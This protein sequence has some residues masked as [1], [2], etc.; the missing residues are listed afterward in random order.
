MNDALY[1]ISRGIYP[2]SSYIA[3]C[4]QLA[5]CMEV[6]ASPKP[7]NIDRHD[8]YADTRYEHFLTSAS[9][10][11]PVV[12]EASSHEKG[13]GQFIKKAV[14]ESVNWQNGGNTHFGAFILL[15]PLAMAAGEIFQE[16]ETFTIQQLV[17]SAYRIVKNTDTEDSINFYSCF[18]AAGVK[19]NPVD[20]FDLRD[21]TAIDELNDKNMTL[22]KLMDIARGYDIIANEWVTGFKRCVRCAETIIDGMNGLHAPKIGADINDVT[23]YAFLKILSENEDTFISTKYNAQTALYVSG[24]AK[25]IIEEIY[26]INENFDTILPM[27]KKLDSELLEKKINPGSTADIVI[28]GLFI[29]LLAGV[30]F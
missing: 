13:V 14:I 21:S 1:T 20:E 17:E 25:K 12:E 8:N 5:M 16:D 9:S 26:K 29:S 4:A 10:V 7:G 23:V 2:L 11:Y 30:R 18:D 3:R 6:S 22:Y 28:A 19:V 15:I 24:R 27:I